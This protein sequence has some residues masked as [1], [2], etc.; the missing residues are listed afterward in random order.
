MKKLVYAIFLI[1]SISY[2]IDAVEQARVECRDF[3]NIQACK[4]YFYATKSLCDKGYDIGCFHLGIIYGTG[5]YGIA[6]T[7][8]EALRYLKPLCDKGFIE[9]ETCMLT[10][11][12]YVSLKMIEMA[13]L[14]IR[15]SCNAGNDF[16]CQFVKEFFDTNKIF[17]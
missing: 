8:G 10:G 17:L 9:T 11:S 4:N 1:L 6:K 3:K 12:I 15:K 5:I 7:D 14:Y 2:A 13:E 16:A